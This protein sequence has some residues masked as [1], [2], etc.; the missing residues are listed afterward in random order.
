VNPCIETALTTNEP[1]ILPV[2]QL[3]KPR[4]GE[5]IELLKLHSEE[6]V[7]LGFEPRCF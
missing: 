5:V 7:D 2:L 4:F 1:S 6:V 3:A